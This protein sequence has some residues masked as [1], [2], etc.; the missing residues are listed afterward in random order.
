MKTKI[1]TALILVML[2]N[3]SPVFIELPQ[4]SAGHNLP[5]AFSWQDIDGVDFTTP[6]KN[7]APAPTCESYALVAS[8]ETLMQ[9]QMGSLFEPDLS[10]THLYFYPGGT[11]E[12]GYV[13][14]VDAA[15]Y[16][17]EFGVPDEGC[18]PDPHRPFDYPF[19]SLPGW[20]NRTV[21][22]QEWGWV[23][24]NQESIKAALIEH[25]PLIV[26]MHFWQD[27]YYYNGGI[28]KHRWGER[29]GGHVMTIVGYDDNTQCWIVK[30]SWGTGWGADGWVRISYD[31]D[32]IADWYGENTGVMYIEGIYGNYEPN[33]PKINIEEPEIYHTYVFGL[34]IPTIFRDIPLVQEAAPRI[35]GNTLVRVIAENTLKVEF[36]IDNELIQVDQEQP[37]EITLDSEPGL[38]T[39]RT[40]AYSEN[41]MSQDIVDVFILY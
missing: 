2:I 35:V 17:I 10:E 38:H 3:I 31:A 41:N 6:I 8:I 28:Y 36:Y 37:F 22:I 12:S 29:A 27:F 13:N 23:E 39:I 5:T 16:L 7:Q 15:N 30:N 26:C 19:E 9:Y 33:V 25:G 40:L 11:Y 14:L 32:M 34:K 1:L 20:E 24:L 4:T 18:Y 21:K